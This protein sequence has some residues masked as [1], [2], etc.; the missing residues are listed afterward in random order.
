[1]KLVR[2]EEP[3]LDVEQLDERATAELIDAIGDKLLTRE[4]R[5]QGPINFADA[6]RRIQQYNSDMKI[7]KL[8]RFGVTGK[9]EDRVTT[10]EKRVDKLEADVEQGFQK[11]D[12]DKDFKD[13]VNKM[14]NDLA[15]LVCRQGNATQ[16][17][18]PPHLLLMPEG[19][20]CG[21]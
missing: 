5:L 1:M 2:M 14:A 17:V 12:G 6:V 19:Q 10:L 3:E 16:K 8:N 20:T 21:T 4:F 11:L 13:A 7:S 15:E 9:D 18:P